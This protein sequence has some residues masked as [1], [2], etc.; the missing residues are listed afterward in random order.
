[1]AAAGGP[2][3]TSA[4]SKLYFSSSTS[5]SYVCS[6]FELKPLPFKLCSLALPVE[7]CSLWALLSL[8]WKVPAWAWRGVYRLFFSML[9][10]DAKSLVGHL[11]YIAVEDLHRRDSLQREGPLSRPR[12]R[13]RNFLSFKEMFP[14]AGARGQATGQ[15]SAL[16][17]RGEGMGEGIL[18]GGSKGGT[19]PR[20]GTGAG[21]LRQPRTG[22]AGMAAIAPSRPLGETPAGLHNPS[23]KRRPP[24]RR[25]GES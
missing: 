5:P 22:E 10:S 4:T 13:R 9:T 12:N 23:G 21:G 3:P 15:R 25:L 19:E 24:R 6:G 8:T 14:P 16:G 11:L 20:G 17:S 1:M 18:M 7:V 2:G